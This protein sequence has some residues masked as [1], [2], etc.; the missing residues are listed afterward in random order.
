[1]KYKPSFV[2]Q[3]LGNG[4]SIDYFN[5]RFVFIVDSVTLQKLLEVNN[6]AGERFNCVVQV[7][8]P[9]TDINSLCKVLND[10]AMGSVGAL[11]ERLHDDRGTVVLNFNP[12]M[13]K[14]FVDDVLDAPKDI[15]PPVR[16]PDGVIVVDRNFSACME[17]NKSFQLV[18]TFDA[19]WKGAEILAEICLHGHSSEIRSL[20]EELSDLMEELKARR[21]EWEGGQDEDPPPRGYVK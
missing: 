9:P 17:S 13:A 4:A 19:N 10:R 7:I 18:Y 21:Q 12:Q 8:V 20:G 2:V 16:T 6:A 14:Q 15:S 5:G 1:M 3:H 11:R